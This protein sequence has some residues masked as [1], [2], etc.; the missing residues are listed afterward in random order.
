MFFSDIVL[1]ACF[2]SLML[3]FAFPI[4]MMKKDIKRYEE[5]EEE[6]KKHSLKL[7]TNGWF[8]IIG[9][10][11]KSQ[12]YLKQLMGT[13]GC[14]PRLCILNIL[15]I[16]SRAERQKYSNWVERDPGFGS[17]NICQLP[18]YLNVA[19]LRREPINFHETLKEIKKRLN[20]PI[21][22]Q[23]KVYSSSS[24]GTSSNESTCVSDDDEK[25]T[26]EKDTF[27]KDICNL[28]VF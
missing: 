2:T 7:L 17:N 23:D 20:K 21:F 22:D 14:I 10:D 3:M 25:D 5:K 12:T 26:F 15:D 6:L 11:Y 8:L 18:F 28:N 13:S 27:E 1:T 9:D 24:S 19:T 16:T 4:Y